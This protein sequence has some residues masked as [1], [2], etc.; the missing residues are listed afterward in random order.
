MEVECCTC[1]KMFE[2]SPGKISR[3]I[4]GIHYCSRECYYTNPIITQKKTGREVECDYCGTIVYRSKSQ[5]DRSKSKRHFCSKKCSNS[6]NSKIVRSNHN[7][8]CTNCGESFRKSPST[9]GDNNY[10]SRDC[11][12]YH[13]RSSGASFYRSFKKEKCEL[14]GFIPVDRCQ[15]DVHHVDSDKDNNTEENLQTLCANCHRLVHK[16]LRDEE[17]QCD[18]S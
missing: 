4:S 1:G 9:I 2:K 8:I 6:Y 7:V 18:I 15:L 17:S 3:T 16:N 14:C 13:V 11:W 12:K 10:C 5:L